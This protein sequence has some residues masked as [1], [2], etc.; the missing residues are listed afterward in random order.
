MRGKVVLEGLDV[1]MFSRALS[2]Q[3]NGGVM[4]KR[5]REYK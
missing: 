3:N 2:Y 5:E 4:V 1:W